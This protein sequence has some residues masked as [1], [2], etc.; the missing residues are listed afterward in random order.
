MP[1]TMTSKR[2]FPR[3]KFVSLLC[4]ASALTACGPQ[5]RRFPLQA[6]LWEDKDRNHVEEEPEE[7]YSGLIAD[8]ADKNFLKPL[9]QIPYLPLDVRA[10]NVNALDEVPNSS[11]FQNRIGF[12]ELSPEEVA[13]GACGDTPSLS[14]D[15]KWEVVAAKPNGAHPGFFIKAGGERYL[16]KFD[17][18]VQPRRATAAD[19]IGSKLYWAAGYH[20][21]CNEIVHFRRENLTVA[22]GASAE[23]KYGK[24]RP[25]TLDDIHTVLKKAY[26][27]HDGRIRASASRFLPGRPIGPFKYDGQ[28]ADDPNDH[29]DHE[30]RRELRGNQ[31]ISAWLHHHDA[32]EQNTLDVWLTDQGKAKKSFI[33][34]YMIDFGDCF[35]SRWSFDPVSRRFGYAYFFDYDQ[36]ALDILTLGAHPRPW[37]HNTVNPEM[38]IFGY[39]NVKDFQPK[40]WVTEYPNAAFDE[41]RYDDGHW[42]ARII[43]RFERPHVEAVVAE[44]KLLDPNIEEYLVDTL[45]GRRKKILEEYLLNYAPLDNFRLVRRKKGDPRQSLCFD[46]LAIENKLIDPKRVL[47]KIRSYGGRLLDEELG[48]LQFYPDPEHPGRSCILRPLGDKR[49]ADFV[50]KDA[51]DDDPLRYGVVKIFVHQEA[52]LRPTSAIHLYFYDLGKER[53]YQLVG[54]ERPDK[55]VVPD[56]Y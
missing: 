22:E 12:H 14:P 7:Y 54:I 19:V 51:P 34:H 8:A 39:F 26:R 56:L 31:V 16:L 15:I 23:D 3:G 41:M 48:W 29:I 36:V 47:Y 2:F 42:M 46:D 43:S 45:M 55:P 5:I 6:P 1:Q 32:R 17:S 20:T 11:W 9:A 24:K 27:T 35:G 25:I 38:E 44:A 40:S 30:H 53:G 33:K 21:P 49:P 37:R 4:L 52:K 13:K 50:E 10:K 18:P 28:R